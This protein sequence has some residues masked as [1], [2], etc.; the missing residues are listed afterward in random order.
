MMENKKTTEVAFRCYVPG[1]MEEL[2]ETIPYT[3]DFDILKIPLSIFSTELNKVARRCAEVNDP[4]LNELM[5]N[6]GM[7]DE[8]NPRSEN[9]DPEKCKKYLKEITTKS[10]TI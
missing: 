8:A 2:M 4:Q 10:K 5:I 6:M 9:Y 7:Y 3:K 1:L